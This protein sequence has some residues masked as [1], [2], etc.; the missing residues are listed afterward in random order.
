[1]AKI[2]NLHFENIN[3]IQSLLEVRKINI[4]SSMLPC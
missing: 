4:F 2:D 1:M 3:S